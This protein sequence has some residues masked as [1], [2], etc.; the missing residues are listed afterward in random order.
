MPRR[1]ST[2]TKAE[3]LALQAE[4]ARKLGVSGETLRKWM[5]PDARGEGAPS[6]AER[7]S[8]SASE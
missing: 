1:G 4:A 8:A 2:L 7:P 6:D 5:L 3:E